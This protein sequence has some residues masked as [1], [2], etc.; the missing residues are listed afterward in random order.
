VLLQIIFRYFFRV[1]KNMRESVCSQVA[2]LLREERERQKMSMTVLAERAGL[3][4][5]SISYIERGMRIPNLD[6]LLRI[7][8]V[9]KIELGDVI[10]RACSAAEKQPR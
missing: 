9:L 10:K 3:S 7:T 6:T 8:G 1:A 5:Q 2:R 4:Q